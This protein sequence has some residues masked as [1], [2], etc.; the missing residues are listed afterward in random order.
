MTMNL[1]N[2]PCFT[3]QNS[4]NFVKNNNHTN[5]IFTNFPFRYDLLNSMSVN[6]NISILNR[7]LQ[8]LVK[9]FPHTRFLETDNNDTQVE[10]NM[11]IETCF[12]WNLDIKE[13]YFSRKLPQFKGSLPSFTLLRG[14][15][16]ASSRMQV[17]HDLCGLQIFC[18]RVLALLSKGLNTTAL[19]D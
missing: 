4:T 1:M 5:I 15:C 8:K 3:L 6:R 11:C 14:N 18:F 17:S 19:N 9:V 16:P 7:K 12:K 10:S 2:T 13:S